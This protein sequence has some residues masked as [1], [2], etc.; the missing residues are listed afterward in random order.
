MTKTAKLIAWENKIRRLAAEEKAVEQRKIV[1]ARAIS[2]TKI[3]LR[4]A[5]SQVGIVHFISSKINVYDFSTTRRPQYLTILSTLPALINSRLNQAN[6]YTESA[7]AYPSEIKIQCT[8]AQ[9]KLIEALIKVAILYPDS[10]DNRSIIDDSIML[11][12]FKIPTIQNEH[13]PPK[14]YVNEPLEDF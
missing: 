9:A 3:D 4:L 14:V 13:I 11:A 12:L 1:R 7:L 8:T 10:K 2:S 5:L 6:G